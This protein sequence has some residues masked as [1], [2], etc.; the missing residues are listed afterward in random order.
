MTDTLKLAEQQLLEPGGLL[1][2]LLLSLGEL[3]VQLVNDR[4]QFGRLIRE[5]VGGHLHGRYFTRFLFLI[6]ALSQSNQIELGPLMGLHTLRVEP[7]EEP[8]QFPQ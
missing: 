7:V 4:L 1:A 3:L 6:R 5:A 2:A 8:V